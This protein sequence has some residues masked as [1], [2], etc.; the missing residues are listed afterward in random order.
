MHFSPDTLD[1]LTRTGF[2]ILSMLLLVGVLYRP[3]QSVPSMP[4]VLSSLNIGLFA[5][6]AAP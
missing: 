3:Q 6:L 5:A 1:L 4:L 2:N